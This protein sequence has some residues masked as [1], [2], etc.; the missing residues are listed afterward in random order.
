MITLSG[1]IKKRNGKKKLI[2]QSNIILND[3][4]RKKR[5]NLLRGSIIAGNDN[6]KL[7]KELSQLT[8]QENVIQNKSVDDI[9]KDLKSLTQ[10]LK[11][12]EGSENVYNHVYNIIDYLRS[13]QHISREQYHKYIK[14]H[15]M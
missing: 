15:L 6:P 3:D 5:I 1:F 11:T 7:L 10:L 2:G 9:Y 12:S 4:D 13:N 8:N 14:K